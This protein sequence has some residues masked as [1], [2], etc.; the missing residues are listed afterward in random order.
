MTR[1]EVLANL[2]R[3]RATAAANRAAKGIVP[4]EKKAPTGAGRQDR[5]TLLANLAR[6]RAAAAAK[7]AERAAEAALNPPEPKRKGPKKGWKQE[8][9]AAIAEKISTD[10]PA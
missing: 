2:A 7:R 4:K 5:E 6:G 9:A 3:A 1:E 10:K 8:L